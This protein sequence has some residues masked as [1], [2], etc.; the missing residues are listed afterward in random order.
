M[1]N[2]RRLG[3]AL[4]LVLLLPV[5]SAAQDS[6]SIAFQRARNLQRGI[7]TS[8][9]FAQS[10]NYSVEHLETFTTPQDIALIHSMGFD[11]I[12]LSVDPGPLEPW[13]DTG[14]P[15]PFLDQLD[16]V[17][18]IMLADHLSVIIDIHPSDEF[19]ATLFHGS[20]S[21]Q[22]FA[23]LWSALAAHFAPVDP[24]HIFFEILNEP[25]Q[26]DLDRWMSV[27][28]TVAAAIRRAAPR[29]TI[30]ATSFHYSGIPDLLQLEPLPDPNIIYTFHDYDPMAFTHQGATWTMPE[31]RPERGIPYPSTPE[32]IAPKLDEEPTLLGQLFLD[33]YGWDRWDAARVENE[34]SYAEK[35]SQLHHV[36]VYCGEFGAFRDY[37][38]P[39]SRAQWIHDMRVALET[40][41]IGWAMWDYQAN[42]GIVSKA[43][44]VTTPNLDVL[45]ALGLHAPQP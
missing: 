6:T 22:N 17:V 44:G 11:H 30:I 34:V 15:T 1:K 12:R 10:G 28:A 39:A 13:V 24:D 45:E 36:P 31:V 5:L 3:P 16:R 14:I 18:R 43:N 2:A 32:N 27:Q 35:W 41:H 40:N 8:M 33:N 9:W 7:N 29:N 25:E 26:N 23:K 19:K 21:V 38:P 4:L 37:A 42:F 20:E